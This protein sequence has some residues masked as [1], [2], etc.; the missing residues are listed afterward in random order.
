MFVHM[1]ITVNQK[2][3]TIEACSDATKFDLLAGFRLTKFD[4]LA[5]SGLLYHVY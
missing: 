4:L 2:A 5:G 1:T 3:A